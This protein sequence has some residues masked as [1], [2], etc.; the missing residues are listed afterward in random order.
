MNEFYVTS[1]AVEQFQT[2]V[3]LLLPKEIRREILSQLS[4]WGCELFGFVK[5]DGHVGPVF[6]GKYKDKK[7]L[8]PMQTDMESKGRGIIIPTIYSIGAANT[9]HWER[10]SNKAKANWLAELESMP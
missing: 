3:A 6:L 4:P 1:H 9:M 8:I 10:N 5:W 2:R 7:Y